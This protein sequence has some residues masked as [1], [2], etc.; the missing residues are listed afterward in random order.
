MLTRYKGPY[1][2]H[3]RVSLN[4]FMLKTL[5]GYVLPS[6]YHVD[7]LKPAKQIDHDIKTRDPLRLPLEDT[8]V[9]FNIST[10]TDQSTHR[11][12]PV[13]RTVVKDKSRIYYRRPSNC[14]TQNKREMQR[15]VDIP[16]LNEKLYN[17]SFFANLLDV[18]AKWRLEGR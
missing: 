2:I 14:A 16:T 15:N 18:I 17:H 4:S 3:S 10:S 12:I 8:N 6:N 7:S 11:Q 13:C 5:K 1:K 9:L